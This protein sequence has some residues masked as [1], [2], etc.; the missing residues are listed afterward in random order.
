MVPK[1]QLDGA[2]KFAPLAP[3]HVMNVVKVRVGS[4][5]AKSVWVKYSTGPSPENATFVSRYVPV[6]LAVW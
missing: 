2:L 4:P 1:F 3:T 6:P 5:V